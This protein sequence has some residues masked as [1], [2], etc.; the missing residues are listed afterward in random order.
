MLVRSNLAFEPDPEVAAP[1]RMAPLERLHLAGFAYPDSLER[2]AGTPYV[3]E[4]RV[5][6]RHV[7]LFLD[8]PQFRNYWHGLHRLLLNSLLLSP[9]F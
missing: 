4:E 3:T 1:F 8:D 5:G 2:L 7:V 9:S 6:S